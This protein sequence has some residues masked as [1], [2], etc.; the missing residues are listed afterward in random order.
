MLSVQIIKLLAQFC[1][2]ELR[3]GGKLSRQVF[4][5]FISL[6]RPG[7]LNLFTSTST[8]VVVHFASEH[9]HKFSTTNSKDQTVY[10]YDKERYPIPKE[11]R[12]AREY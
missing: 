3:T 12:G 8:T 5:S 1:Q 4:I 7:L 9:R 11:Y 6:S 2:E 10:A